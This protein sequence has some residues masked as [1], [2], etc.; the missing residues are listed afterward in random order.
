[1]N[2][3]I[4]KLN[5]ILTDSIILKMDFRIEAL[6]NDLEGLTGFSSAE[7]RGHFVT[8]ISPDNDLQKDLE[9]KLQKGYFDNIVANLTTKDG[10]PLKV[11]MSGFYLGL[12]SEINGYII[13]KV[14]LIEDNLY[15]KKELLIQKREVDSFIYRTAHDLR[16]P[17]ATIK[18]LINLLKIR[19]TNQ[20]VDE[21]TN[22]IDLHAKKLDDRLFKLLYLASANNP[23][24]DTKSFISFSTL[25][26]TL[27]KVLDDNCQLDNVTFRFNAPDLGL[28]GISEHGVSQ[29]ISNIF[30]YIIGLPVATV[31]AEYDNVIEIDFTLEQNTLQVRIKASGFLTTVEIQNAILQPTS[32]YQDVL[33]HPLLFNYY[34]AKK[35]AVQ[36][37]AAFNIEFNNEM[38]QTLKLSIPMNSS[39]ESEVNDSYQTQLNH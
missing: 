38:E 32:L 17:L 27:N 20:E 26:T 7:L 23:S 35:M 22:M 3:V 1:M 13:L 10:E 31:T 34:V 18:G 14:K 21:L 28:N 30:F 19:K 9:N 12:I 39:I 8:R 15:L 11:T 36:L 24:E 37:N 5:S 6:S 2:D 16:G 4:R 33:I 25:R 29:L